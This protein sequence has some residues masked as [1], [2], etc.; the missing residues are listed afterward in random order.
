MTDKNKGSIHPGSKK[1][2]LKTD[3]QQKYGQIEHKHEQGWRL[4]DANTT[5]NVDKT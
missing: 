4:G 2:G 1:D 5:C 3:T